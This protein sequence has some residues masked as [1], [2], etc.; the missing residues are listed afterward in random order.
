M[1]E[2]AWF[3]ASG[4]FQNRAIGPLTARS[5]FTP[6]R[7]RG[8][9]LVGDAPRASH[10]GGG[11][12]SRF[13]ITLGRVNLNVMAA[14]RKSGA[15]GGPTLADN[16]KSRFQYQ[17]E[18]KLEA[19]L[20]LLG[21][22]VKAIREGKASL[23]DAYV[24]IRRGEAF[25]H[26]CHIGPYSSASPESHEARRD[27]KLLMHRREI[28]RLEGKARQRG[29]TLIVTRLYL[30]G[31]RVKAEVALARGKKLHDKRAVKR[32][33]ELKREAERAMKLRG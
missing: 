23:A 17:V 12:C 31:G 28:D 33:H 11:R 7:L 14:T 24:R 26:G 27:R 19:G 2:G 32:D 3:I 6:R 16:R 30:K 15:K 8:L 29:L 18:E 21:S 22:E 25:L 13:W 20:S 9:P 1:Q 5:F 4:A 10:R